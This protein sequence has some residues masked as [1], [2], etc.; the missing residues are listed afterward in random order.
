MR[1]RVLFFASLKDEVG[2]GALTLQVHDSGS[3]DALFEALSATIPETAIVLLQAEN[4]RLA[5]NQ[6]LVTPPLQ[7]RADDE[8]AFLP[9]VTGG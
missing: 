4:V 5:V 7:L 6:Q 3:M 2:E 9:P 8:V 1:I